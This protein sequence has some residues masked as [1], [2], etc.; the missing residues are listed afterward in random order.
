MRNVIL[1][2][3]M[4]VVTAALTGCAS[5]IV[6]TSQDIFITSKPDGATIKINGEVQGKTPMTLKL[7]RGANQKIVHIE[8]DGYKTHSTI[9]DTYF[10][11]RPMMNLMLLVLA[12]IG[13]IID[14]STGVAYT[15]TPSVIDAELLP[16]TG[17]P[18]TVGAPPLR[19]EDQAPAPKTRLDI[20]SK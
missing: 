14:A 17:V 20:P 8:R 3:I 12:P 2:V 7:H 18:S 16:I 4:I 13:I 15:Y 5:I 19:K 10:R 1:L 9:L 11:P 6:G